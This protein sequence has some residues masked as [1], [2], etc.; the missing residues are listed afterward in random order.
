[1]T[2]QPTN[3]LALV[4]LLNPIKANLEDLCH[5][6]NE[7]KTLL[8]QQKIEALEPVLLE[9]EK[10][11]KTLDQQTVGLKNFFNA[12]DLS[13]SFDSVENLLKDAPENIKEL[14]NQFIVTLQKAQEANLVN[15]MLVMGMKNYN[16]RL[17]QLLTQRSPTYGPNQTDQQP[18]STREHKA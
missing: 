5:T 1:M 2:T 11:F 3:Y 16:D 13:F 17:L 18:L 6:L 4:E 9:K 12:D 8:E 15:G 10:Q 7:E 14:W